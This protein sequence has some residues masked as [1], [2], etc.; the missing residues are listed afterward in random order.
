MACRTYVLCGRGEL[1]NL[2]EADM[3]DWKKLALAA[4]LAD[5]TIDKTEVKILKKELYADGKIDKQELQFLMEL[6]EQAQK[7]AK[8]KELD[9]EFEK[10]FFKAVE[11]RVLINGVINKDGATLLRQ[12]IFTEKNK[13]AGEG[14]K[15]FLAKLKKGA[16]KVHGDFESLCTEC[17]GKQ[18][19]PAAAAAQNNTSV[20]PTRPARDPL[21]ARRANGWAHLA[22]NASTYVSGSNNSRSSSCS[23]TPMNFT[24]KSS[25]CLTPKIAPPLAVPSSFDKIM[26]VH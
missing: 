19:A 3:A 10:L 6:R 2:G 12:V 1:P 4:I 18:A 20:S 23:P 16:T 9:P 8:D 5:G 22:N 25:F 15:K 7:K 13:K 17:L 11:D 14:E 21:L 26:P 24:G